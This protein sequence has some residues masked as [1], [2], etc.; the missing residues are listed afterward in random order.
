MRPEAC[1]A[2]VCEVISRSPGKWGLG[3][4]WQ[5][6]DSKMCGH[7]ESLALPTLF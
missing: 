5:G 7:C 1:A 6:L 3:W 2:D 4:R